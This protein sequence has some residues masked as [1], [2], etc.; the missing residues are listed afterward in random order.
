M[1]KTRDILRKVKEEGKKAIK[2]EIIHCDS[3][4]QDFVLLFFYD[5]RKMHEEL[6]HP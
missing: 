1:E 2:S 4:R 5:I 6:N 3:R